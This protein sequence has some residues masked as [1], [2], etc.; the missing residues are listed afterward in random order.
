M[1]KISF[2]VILLFTVT[3]CLSQEIPTEYLGNYKGE[4]KIF[5]PQEVK[6]LQMEFEISATD[7]IGQ[8]HY[9]L[10][11][12]DTERTDVRN[13]KLISNKAEKGIF[14][15]DEN[16]GIKIPTTFVN[17]SLQSLFKVQN[18]LLASKISFIENAAVFE[19]SM[20]NTTRVDST[21][22]YDG[23]F[24]VEGFPIGTYQIAKLKKQ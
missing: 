8:Y 12:I 9:I 3:V 17:N 6:N 19:I 5:A 18:S 1:K 23:N 22:T 11:Y 21:Q 7:T 14:T 10:K 20:A 13:Y 24:K 2:I 4:L 15:L 16:N